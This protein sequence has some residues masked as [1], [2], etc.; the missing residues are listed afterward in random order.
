MSIKSNG[1]NFGYKAVKH[2]G[3]AEWEALIKFH[4]KPKSPQE[5]IAAMWVYDHLELKLRTA[6]RTGS[7]AGIFK[8]KHIFSFSVFDNYC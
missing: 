8:R 4:D 6:S 3:K 5:K 7:N 1:A 2:G